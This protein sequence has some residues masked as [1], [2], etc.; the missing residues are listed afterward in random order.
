MVWFR[1]A[2]ESDVP[3]IVALLADDSVAK[4]REGAAAEVYLAAFAAIRDDPSVV[5]LVAEDDGRITA[6]AQLTFLRGLSRGGMIRALVEAVRVAPDLRSRGVGAAL[7]AE[8]EARARTAGAGMVQLT[9]DKQRTR[10]HAFYRRL[11]YDQ[12][13]EG[14]KKLL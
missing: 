6:T 12:S 8:I 7:M 2:V 5:M 10:A 13:H 14:F 4:G 3:G 11:G 1:E 9:S